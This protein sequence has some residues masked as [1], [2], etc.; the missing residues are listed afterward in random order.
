[1][2]KSKDIIEQLLSA[3]RLKAIATEKES[4]DSDRFTISDLE[5]PSMLLM[6]NAGLA[7]AD[8]I[9]KKIRQFHRLHTKVMV[10]AGKGNNGADAVVSARHLLSR[11]ID[12]TLVLVGEEQSFRTEMRHQLMLFKNCLTSRGSKATALARIIPFKDLVHAHSPNV[13][14]ALI[15]VDGIFGSG[16]N[17]APSGTALA[18]IEWINNLRL[19]CENDSMVISI[20]IPSGLSLEARTFAGSAVKAD[21]T[22]TFGPL[23]RAQI[24][25]PTKDWC[26]KTY[27][28]EIGLFPDPEHEHG[29]FFVQKQ[30]ALSELF[31]ETPK[32]CHKGNFGHV[33]VFEGHPRYRGASRLSGRAALRVG[34]GLVTLITHGA[35]AADIPEFMRCDHGE[36]SDHL[37]SKIDALVIGPGL[38]SEATWQEK[39]RAFLDRCK[40]LSP[41]MVFDAD[42]LRLLNAPDFPLTGKTIVATPHAQEAA[43]LLGCKAGEVERDRFFAIDA[44]ANL[45]VSNNNH[46]IWVLKG[47]T[48]LVRSVDGHRFAFRG[49][50]PILAAGGSGD[51]LS[52]AI[53]GLCKQTQTPLAAVLLA[54]SL[55][56]EAARVLSR[57]LFKGIFAS[58]LADI[59]PHLARR[60]R[61]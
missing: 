54:I 57:R 59:F 22:V 55:Q 48:P 20:D 34:A 49:D 12:V 28:R 16:L 53:A 2:P 56:L 13:E 23:K 60:N 31:I 30:K 46:V 7:V 27:P 29:D 25:E 17:R 6:E 36:V 15:L 10:F 9:A 21:F 14:S 35:L 41:L 19:R 38:S 52:G 8:V 32:P 45:K 11:N 50:A 61:K 24:S 3:G 51:V 58:E 26:G 33:M 47:A 42:G 5:I 18:A 40:N 39:A 43:N 44:L 37:L 1:M 4:I